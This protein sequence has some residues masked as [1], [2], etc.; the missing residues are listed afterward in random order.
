MTAR[1]VGCKILK[2]HLQGLFIINDAHLS[3]SSIMEKVNEMAKTGNSNSGN[4]A[5]N[6][7]KASEAGRKGGQSSGQGSSGKG[8]GSNF[9][10][11]RQKAS[12]AGKKG[13]QSSRSGGRDS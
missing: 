4:F 2:L 6:P 11:D 8:S 7:E 9:A 1:L 13:G 12:E 5:N 3:M 10:D